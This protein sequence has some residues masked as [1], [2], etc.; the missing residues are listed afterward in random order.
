MKLSYISNQRLPTEKAYGI[1]IAKTCEAFADLYIDV[2]LTVPYR[3]SDIKENLFDYYFVKRNF[4]FEETFSPDFY[5]SGKSDKV[6]F[7]IKN[8]I[9]AIVLVIHSLFSKADIVYSRDEPIIFLLSFFKKSGDL[10]FEAHRFSNS[11]GLLYER[12]KNKNLKIVAISHGLK[13]KFLEFGFKPENILVAPDGV[14]IEK[15]NINKIKEECRKEL[16]LPLDK[17]IVLYSGHLFEWKGVHVL[18]AAAAYLQEVLFVFVGG[19][20]IDVLKFREKF[21]NEKNIKILGQK[22][23]KEIPLFLKTAD[24]LVLP[25]SAREMFSAL[26]TSPLK[27]FEYMVSRRPIVASNLPSIREVLNERNSILVKPDDAEA[28][29]EGIKKALGDTAFSDQISR[30]AFEDVKEYT[31]EKRAAKIQNYITQNLPNR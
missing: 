25:N 29:A 6:A 10:I 13:N 9:S 15:F 16:G 7:A 4:K 31:W 28:L 20:E 8:F 3:R 17:K 22:P 1:Q 12:F 14:D 30:T 27:L 19:T 21:G 26:Y 5:L 23:H 2:I 24:V 18:A 11:R